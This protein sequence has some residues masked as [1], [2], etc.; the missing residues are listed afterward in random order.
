PDIDADVKPA[1]SG[2]LGHDAPIAQAR[3]YRPAMSTERLRVGTPPILQL[4]VL[5]QALTAWDGVDMAELR[6]ASLALSDR[7]IAEVEARCPSLELVTPRDHAMRGSQVSFRFEHGYAA[8]Q[9]LIDRGVIGDFRAP[10]IMR[11]G[12]TPLYIDEADVVA[13]AGIIDEVISTEAWRDPKYQIR[14]RVT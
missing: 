14:S 6:A 12:F 1:L 10:D 9:A 2:R 11:F 5:Q 4:R 7:F 8:M 13:A 3:H